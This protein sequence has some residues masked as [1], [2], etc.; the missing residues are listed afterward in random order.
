MKKNKPSDGLGPLE[1]AKIRNSIRLVWQRSHPRRVA[2]KRCTRPDGF[3]VCEKCAEVTPDIKI[4]HIIQV[5]DL[6]EGFLKRLFCSSTGLQG[7]C[8]SCHN[9]KTKAERAAQRAA[10]FANNFA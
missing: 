1:I 6:D 5:G 7:L 2:V 4:D 3:K 10:R 8:R 9:E